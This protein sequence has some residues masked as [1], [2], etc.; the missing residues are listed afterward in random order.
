MRPQV[1]ERK[2]IKMMYFHRFFEVFYNQYFSISDIFEFQVADTPIYCRPF[3]EKGEKLPTR[4]PNKLGKRAQEMTFRS[5]KPPKI[6]R[7]SRGN[8]PHEKN[9]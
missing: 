8:P 1:D 4:D 5:W 7:A 6:F 9:T 2:E 3:M